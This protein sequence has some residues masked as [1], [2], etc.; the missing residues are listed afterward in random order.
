MKNILIMSAIAVASL[1][2]GCATTESSTE[3]AAERVDKEYVTGSNIPKKGKGDAST[4]DR[5]ALGGARNQMP[6]TP[7]PGLGGTP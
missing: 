3:P 1:A 6:M 2:A 4:Y 7:R 5:E